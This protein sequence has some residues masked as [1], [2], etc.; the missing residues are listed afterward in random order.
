M[1]ARRLEGGMLSG[2]ALGK[3][4]KHRGPNELPSES[5]SVPDFRSLSFVTG[6]ITEQ[7]TDKQVS[8][9]FRKQEIGHKLH[10]SH[11]D[12]DWSLHLLTVSSSGKSAS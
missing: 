12:L 4:R 7:I 11:T 8:D 1:M 5:L 3:N 10:C 6:Q 9:C 2:D